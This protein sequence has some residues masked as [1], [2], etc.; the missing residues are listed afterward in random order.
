MKRLHAALRITH[1]DD[2]RIILLFVMVLRYLKHLK[3]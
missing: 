1:P 3:F 2:Y